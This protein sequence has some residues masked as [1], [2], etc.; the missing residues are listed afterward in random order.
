MCD[1]HQCVVPPE[2]TADTD[3]TD[4]VCSD[5]GDCVECKADGDCTDGTCENN[6]CKPNEGGDGNTDDG[7][8]TSDDEC[9]DDVLSVCN[10]ATGECVADNSQPDLCANAQCEADEVCDSATGD[11]VPAGGD[12]GDGNGG[13]G[14]GDNG[15]DNGAGAAAALS[16]GAALFALIM[17]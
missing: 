8:C 16:V 3:C 1:N 14:N 15:D 12:G 2:C 11:C 13:D 5:E 4:G 9:T 7:T 10:I 6:V 17:A